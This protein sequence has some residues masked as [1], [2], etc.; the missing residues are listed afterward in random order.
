MIPP[1]GGAGVGVGAGAGVGVGAGVDVGV[2]V[3]A[4]VAAV[5]T[6]AP[7]QVPADERP[8]FVIV[9]GAPFNRTESGVS[10]DAA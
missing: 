8:L 4:G 3:G 9:H 2:G 10:V 6:N 7:E 1:S 5:C